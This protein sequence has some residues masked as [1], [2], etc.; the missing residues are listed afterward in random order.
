MFVSARAKS[1]L[2]YVPPSTPTHSSIGVWKTKVY[3]FVYN[4]PYI[5]VGSFH[6]KHFI[7]NGSGLPLGFK[8]NEKSLVEHFSP[9]LLKLYHSNIKEN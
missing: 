9:S 5:E 1:D 8:G 2:N 6:L 4:N 3:L 7:F